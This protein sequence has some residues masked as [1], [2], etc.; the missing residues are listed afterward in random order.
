MP[1]GREMGMYVDFAVWIEDSEKH[2]IGFEN[3][4]LLAKYVH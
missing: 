2:R 4:K 1:K 3:D